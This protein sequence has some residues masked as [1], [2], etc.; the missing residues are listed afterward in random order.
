MQEQDSERN[1]APFSL[2]D[3]IRLFSLD[4]LSVLIPFSTHF[5]V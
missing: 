2:S 1:S 4:I 3:I 5:V